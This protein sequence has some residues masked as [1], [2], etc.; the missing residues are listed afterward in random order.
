MKIQHTINN[1]HYIACTIAV[2]TQTVYVYDS[3]R[4]YGAEG[5]DAEDIKIHFRQLKIDGQKLYQIK[6]TTKE[7]KDGQSLPVFIEEDIEQKL[8]IEDRVVEKVKIIWDRLNKFDSVKKVTGPQPKNFEQPN[9]WKLHWFQ[10]WIHQEDDVSCGV[11]VAFFFETM[12]KNWLLA[13]KNQQLRCEERTAWLN[14]TRWNGCGITQQYLDKNRKTLRGA[15]L[16]HYRLW[17]ALSISRAR[18]SQ[19][20]KVPAQKPLPR[21]GEKREKDR[22][23]KKEDKEK[24]KQAKKKRKAEERAMKEQEKDKKKRKREE[25]RAMREQQEEQK[26]AKNLI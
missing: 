23:L 24:E 6:Q 4:L 21:K 26:R 16:G 12:T 7:K 25:E 15:K 20:N 2:K 1:A 17:M 10:N 9:T 19:R 8:L 11:F 18:F 14:K 22:R 13:Y 3:K 5:K